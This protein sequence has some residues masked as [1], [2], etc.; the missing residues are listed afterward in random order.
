MFALLTHRK[1]MYLK[2]KQIIFTFFD[3][4]FSYGSGKFVI[5]GPF[6]NPC[7][8]RMTVFYL[9]VLTLLPVSCYGQTQQISK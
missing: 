5:D 6:Y 1:P 7:V 2:N 4:F 8:T 9:I 3:V